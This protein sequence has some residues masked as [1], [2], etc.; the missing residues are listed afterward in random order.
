MD[1]ILT[2]DGANDWL[3]PGFALGFTTLD[4][5]EYRTGQ[6]AYQ[7][8]KFLP[9]EMRQRLRGLTHSAEALELG[10]SEPATN[11]QWLES[12]QRRIE[13][14]EGCMRSRFF[15]VYMRGKLLKTKDA[16]LEFGNSGEQ[17]WG[18]AEGSGHHPQPRGRNELG[19]AIMRVRAGFGG[20]GETRPW[21]DM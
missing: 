12:H 9:G 14:M 20:Y 15:C 1:D 3:H 16:Y 5:V 13:V 2:F 11:P 21:R 17:F 7:A 4:G 10:R 6:H 18:V 19:R 8:F